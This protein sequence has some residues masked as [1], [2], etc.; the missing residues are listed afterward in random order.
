MSKSGN[1]PKWIRIHY[2]ESDSDTMK[3]YIGSIPYAGKFVEVFNRYKI[4]EDSIVSFV[5]N[6]N[7]QNNEDIR[8]FFIWLDK[9]RKEMEEIE[10]RKKSNSE[11]EENNDKSWIKP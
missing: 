10:K 3:K 7:I 11:T 4:K 9:A 8:K 5:V 2:F 1:Y 6:D